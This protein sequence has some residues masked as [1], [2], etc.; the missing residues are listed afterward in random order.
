[1]PL[2]LRAGGVVMMSIPLSLLIGLALVQ[3]FGFTVNQLTIA[4][5]VLALGLLVDDSIVVT[6][7][8]AR[9]L[10]MGLERTEAGLAAARRGWPAGCSRGTRIRKATACCRR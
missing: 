3:M 9:H 2:G 8:I 5:F 6:E 10:P 4:G 7:N 1:L